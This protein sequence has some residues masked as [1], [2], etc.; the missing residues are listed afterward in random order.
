M[1]SEYLGLHYCPPEEYM[2]HEDGPESALDF[3][4]RCA[5]LCLKHKPV[6]LSHSTFIG[7]RKRSNY[8]TKNPEIVF[9]RMAHLAGWFLT[10]RAGPMCSQNHRSISNKKIKNVPMI[11]NWNKAYT[12]RISE[13]ILLLGRLCN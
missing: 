7:Y 5:Q 13:L 9:I 8:R 4:L 10:N 11:H 6:S 3:P 2:S 1:V 12:Y